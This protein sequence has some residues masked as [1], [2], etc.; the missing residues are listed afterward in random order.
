MSENNKLI[1]KIKHL[2][3][4][5]GLP[6]RLHH[7]G[8]KKFFLWQL[9]LGLL[10]KEAFRLSYRRASAFL[11]EFYSINV[12]WTSL[13]KFRYRIPLHIW[14]LILAHTVCEP[15]PVA[16]ID[17]T[18]LQRSNPSSHYLK[19]IDRGEK[20][21]I[22]V[23]LNVMVD[24]LRR[25]F[26][27]IR[28]HASRAGEQ[29]DVKYL[30]NQSPEKIDLILM[31]K[32]YD[33]EKLHKLIREKGMLSIAP[34]KKNWKRGQLRKQLRDCFDYVIYW[35]RN[36]I[37]SLFSALKRLFGSHLRGL[38]SRTQRAEI[39][40]RMIAYNIGAKFMEIFY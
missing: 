8:P 36:L 29:K 1:H 18:C 7:F 30:I 39:Y 35:Q 24:V 27:S 13:Q 25:K 5:A 40:M 15:I 10:V 28:H 19:R 22:P 20:T 12:H 23:Q 31:D 14:K 26:V 6:K 32:G 16:A 34:V 2:T 9:L 38:T 33:S 4:K 37:E 11:L 3:K 21:Q 17:G